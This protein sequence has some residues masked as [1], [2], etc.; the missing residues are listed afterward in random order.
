MDLMVLRERNPLQPSPRTGRAGAGGPAFRGRP[1][2]QFD[3]SAGNLIVDLFSSRF[4]CGLL[5]QSD[6][7]G[8]HCETHSGSNSEA[9]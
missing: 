1:E 3:V 4:V 5:L 9:K 2:R 8:S 6:R 7:E